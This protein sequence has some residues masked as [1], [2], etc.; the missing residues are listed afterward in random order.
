MTPEREA[1]IRSNRY[2]GAAS[3]SKDVCDLI[4]ALDASR[5]ELDQI[6]KTRDRLTAALEESTE[7]ISDLCGKYMT[8]WKC[9]TTVPDVLCFDC[10]RCLRLRLK[11]CL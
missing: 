8:S 3:H 9:S 4:D 11:E 1:E 2:Y 10:I 6:K 7:S 5:S